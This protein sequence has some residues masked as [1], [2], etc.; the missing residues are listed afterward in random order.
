MKERR[1]LLVDASYA[2]LFFFFF[3]CLFVRIKSDCIVKHLILEH[4]LDSTSIHSLF[5]SILDKMFKESFATLR[6]YS[7]RPEKEHLKHLDL[8]SC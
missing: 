2:V 7:M 5:Y 3:A 6:I 8:P 4:V 1:L